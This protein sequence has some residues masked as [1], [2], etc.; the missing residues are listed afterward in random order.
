MTHFDTINRT[1]GLPFDAEMDVEVRRL[2]VLIPGPDV[3]LMGVTH[4]VWELAN[5]TGA[6]VTFLGLWHD[7]VEE[8]GLRRSLVT[9]TALVN[10]RDVSADGEMIF[11]KDWVEAARPFCQAGDMIVCLAEQCEGIWKKPL[12]QILES[13]L[14][15]P[16]YILSG[17]YEQDNSYFSWPARVTTWM[18]FIAIILGSLLL[19]VKI[20]QLANN[21]TALWMVLAT[22]IEFWLIWVWN[23]LFK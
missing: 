18:G 13:N 16:V 4:R 1:L 12:G 8:P 9:M 7:P 5:A 3:D 21:W 14:D 11:G 10:S 20:Y 22:A 15:V 6:H 17:L 19:Q 23:N 2:I